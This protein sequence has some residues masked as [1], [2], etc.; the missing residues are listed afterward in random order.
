[1]QSGYYEPGEKR[2]ARVGDLFAAIAPRYDLINDLQSVGCHRLW[3]RRL[4]RLAAPHPGQCALDLCCG[5]GDV[6][7]SL[8]AQ[9]AQVVGLDFSEPMLSV[10]RRR[11]AVRSGAR[12]PDRGAPTI[13]GAPLNPALVRGDALQLPFPDGSFDVVT[14]SYG[15]RNLADWEHGLRE[16]LRVTRA[17]GQLLV[18]DFGK[19]DN[20]AWRACYFAYLRVCVPLFGWVFCGDARTHAYILTSLRHYP[21]H[22]VVAAKMRD[23]GCRDTR[24]LPLL[25][26][27]MTI[28]QGMKA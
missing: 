3:K 6:A 12:A 25:G 10:A 18:L 21:A 4:V 2:A 27:V 5:T 11:R 24:I 20:A 9:G 16:M 26:G 14:I 7:L 17:G 1:M 28:H 23:L 19:P 15:L 8:A 13:A 22:H